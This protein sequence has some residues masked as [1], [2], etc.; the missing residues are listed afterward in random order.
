MPNK[1]DENTDYQALIDAAVQSGDYASAAKNE[2]YRNQKIDATG[3][4]YAKT[5]EYEGYLDYN[6]DAD[7]EWLADYYAKNGD[8]SGAWGALYGDKYSRSAKQKDY[9]ETG[10]IIESMFRLPAF[11]AV[12]CV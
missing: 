12:A 10:S 8:W 11:A 3:L 5:H 2:Q 6:P 1:W 7:Y 4:P 9:G